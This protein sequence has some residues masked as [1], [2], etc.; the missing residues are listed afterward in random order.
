MNLAIGSL[1]RNSGHRAPVYFE[2]VAALKQQLGGAR[3]RVIALEGDS[4]D[5]TREALV[6]AAEYYG[7]ELQLL[8]H[9]HGGPVFG[10]T[11]ETARMV[12]LSGCVNALLD[13]V[14]H[15]DDY[16]LYVESDLIWKPRSMMNLLASCLAHQERYSVI[17]P[18][19]YAADTF[20]D[21][22][23]FRG[24]D[25]VRWS[26]FPPYHKDYAAAADDFEPVEVSSAGS[27]L[28]MP[29]FIARN[30]RVE[31]DYALVGWCESVRRAGYRIGVERSSQVDQL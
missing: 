6:A 18:M 17:A 19:V 25:G 22:W 26:P 2:R 15:A 5:N 21:I 16:F 30:I 24:L 12:A 3:V 9:N 7:I 13:G 29:S 1:W 14:R 8:T 28:V 27:C 31:N 10:S 4:T 23:G 20:Y 11:E